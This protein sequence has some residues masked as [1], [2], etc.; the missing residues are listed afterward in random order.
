[1]PRLTIAPWVW[2]PLRWILTGLIFLVCQEFITGSLLDK[3]RV[4][5]SAAQR[6]SE[7]SECRQ[8]VRRLERV[9]E[10]VARQNAQEWLKGKSIAD[11]RTIGKS[12][13]ALFSHEKRKAIGKKVMNSVCR[14]APVPSACNAVLSRHKAAALAL[15]L[16]ADSVFELAAHDAVVVGLVQLG[17]SN[18]ID[19]KAPQELVVSATSSAGRKICSAECQ[20]VSLF[21]TLMPA[22]LADPSLQAVLQAAAGLWSAIFL[23]ILVGVLL[24]L[25]LQVRAAA[26]RRQHQLYMRLV[27][28][29]RHRVT[30]TGGNIDQVS[31]SN[32]PGPTGRKGT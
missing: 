9:L 6:R 17:D 2:R 11:V 1:M 10:E 28:Q 18:A 22:V 29:F 16:G 26:A 30:F 12:P 27:S 4:V 14:S 24:V 5:D 20:I 15:I 21:E 13:A 7:C 23:V 32:N 19:F 8:H 31:P 25:T 3:L